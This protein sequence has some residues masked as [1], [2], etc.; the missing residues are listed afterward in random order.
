MPQIHQNESN[1]FLS[2]SCSNDFF[3]DCKCWVY[4][5]TKETCTK[6]TLPIGWLW[7]TPDAVEA[8][9]LSSK[10]LTQ[11]HQLHYPV[12]R[13]SFPTQLRHA[14]KQ[15]LYWNWATLPLQNSSLQS[16]TF[17]F[18]K[19]TQRLGYSF[20]SRF[21]WRQF[22]VSQCLYYAFYR[23]IWC[24]PSRPRSATAIHSSGMHRTPNLP[25]EKR[26]LHRWTVAAP[27]KY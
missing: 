8:C 15:Q 3:Y 1:T 7:F 26:T 5:W 11:A 22:A 6:S 4:R 17:N 25:V 10:S 20:F 24:E 2:F 16:P 19:T 12:S 9:N 14:E 27:T 23:R 21:S 13:A 18:D